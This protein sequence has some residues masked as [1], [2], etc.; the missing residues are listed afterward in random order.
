M[1]D[2][3]WL[4][5]AERYVIIV[6][7]DKRQILI[8]AYAKGAMNLNKRSSRNLHADVYS[9]RATWERGWVV[10]TLLMQYL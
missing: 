10:G 3:F 4:R 2:D 9:L 6:Y 1:I 5:L 7:N 8:S